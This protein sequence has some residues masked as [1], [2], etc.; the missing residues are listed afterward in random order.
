[1][2]RNRCGV[3]AALVSAATLNL[4]AQSRVPPTRPGASARVMSY[5]ESMPQPPD[6]FAVIQG[7]AL[8]SNN[9]PLPNV[10][11][12]LRDARFGGIRAAEVTDNAGLF[13]FRGLDPG[14]YVVELVGADHRVLAAS[15][16]LTVSAGETVSAVVKLPS[17]KPLL[18]GLPGRFAPSAVIVTSAAAASAIVVATTVGAPTCAVQ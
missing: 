10:N 17:R 5:V 13:A 9:G 18:A 8:D 16:M 11:V 3:A 4:I 6:A 7:N 15:Q 1:M 12:R 14:I 2:N